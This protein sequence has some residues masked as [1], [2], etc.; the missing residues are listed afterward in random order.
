VYRDRP[1]KTL[2]ILTAVN[3]GVAKEP[4]VTYLK[5]FPAAISGPRQEN[6]ELPPSTETQNPA[7][8]PEHP[9]TAHPPL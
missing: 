6:G 2:K 1:K 4:F 5:A 8:H 9:L 3:P 7:E